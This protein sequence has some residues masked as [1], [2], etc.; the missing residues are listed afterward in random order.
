VKFKK[1]KHTYQY[2]E[3]KV[4]PGLF[5]TDGNLYCFQVAAFKSIKPAKELKNKLNKSGH[6]SFIVKTGNSNNSKI[7]YK[8]RIGYFKSLQSAKNYKEKFK[9]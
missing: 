3:E 2:S 7:L 1:V 6:H 8:I 9:F 5:F 4:L